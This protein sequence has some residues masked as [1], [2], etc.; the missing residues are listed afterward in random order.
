MSSSAPHNV[1]P[2]ASTGQV[3]STTIPNLHRWLIVITVMLVAIL[4]ILDST[5]VNVALPAMQASLGA[6][7]DQITWVLTSYIVASA[8]MIPLTGFLSD[9]LSTKRLLLINITGFLISS[10]LCGISTSLLQ[11]VC[12]RALQG[13]FGAALIP[14]SQSVLRQ[15]FP[16]EQQG[17][18]MAIWGI[19]IMAAPVLGPSLGGYI[20]S[21]ASWRWIFYIN[22]PFCLLSLLLAIIYIPQTKPIFRKIALKE[23]IYMIIGISC[24]QLFL[25]QGNSH[26]W[27]ESGYITL[28]AIAAAIGLITFATISLRS[29]KPLVTLRL[30]ANRNLAISSLTL[31]LFS[32]SVFS[33]LAL[34][35]IMLESLFQYTPLQVG[36]VMAPRGVSSALAMMVCGICMQRFDARILMIIG[37][38]ASACAA[39]MLSHISLQT[40]FDF[41]LWQGVIQGFGMGLIMVPLSYFALSTLSKREITEGAGLFSY[42]R[43]L[44]TSI[45]ISVFVTLFSHESQVSWHSLSG[46]ISPYRAQVQNWLLKQGYHMHTAPAAQALSSEVA[47]QS[48]MIGFVDSFYIMAIVLFALIPFLFFIKKADPK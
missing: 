8:I 35:P 40:S 13:A 15:T 33:M 48:S 1:E 34:Q 44:G 7:T 23:L 20:T 36:Y 37:M 4:E 29:H 46:K 22:V 24:L 2:T 21:N 42:G 17:K 19:G 27:F 9:R 41:Y 43:Q 32:A 30:F 25:D 28:L 16:P 11:I 5:I 31:A 12:I 45:G 3:N 10:I 6:N 26:A 14:L 18:A 38:T 39:L 47:R